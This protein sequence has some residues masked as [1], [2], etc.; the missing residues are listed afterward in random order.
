MDPL[1]HALVPDTHI[2]EFHKRMAHSHVTV[3]PTTFPISSMQKPFSNSQFSGSMHFTESWRLFW[4]VGPQLQST[5]NWFYKPFISHNPQLHRQLVLQAIHGLWVMEYYCQ[6]GVFPMTG[7]DS[8]KRRGMWRGLY[9]VRSCFL[10]SIPN[11]V[12]SH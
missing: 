6:N 4:G 5:G 7:F 9:H 8:N 3:E 12:S 2:P 10:H 1:H 11:T